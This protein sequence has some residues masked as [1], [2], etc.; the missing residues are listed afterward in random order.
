MSNQYFTDLDFTNT[1][2]GDLIQFNGTTTKWNNVTSASASTNIY[3][4]DGTLT[5]NRVLTQGAN[6]IDFV[7]T[8]NFTVDNTLPSGRTAK[9]EYGSGIFGTPSFEGAGTC[10]MNVG[11][12]VRSCIFNGIDTSGANL[13]QASLILQ[14]LPLTGSSKQGALNLA[15][16][17]SNNYSAQMAVVNGSG[18]VAQVLCQDSGAIQFVVT[19]VTPLVQVTLGTFRI[20]PLAGSG[21][22]NLGINAS[23]DVVVNETL[24][25]GSFG[26]IGLSNI[27]NCAV[28]QVNAPYYQQVG[29][30][31]NVHFHIHLSTLTVPSTFSFDMNLPVSRSTSGNFANTNEAQG[32][33]NVCAINS[34]AGNVHQGAGD[35]FMDGFVSSVTGAQT[36]R[37]QCGVA[38]I[39]NT[40][41]VV[42]GSFSYLI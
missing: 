26:G 11:G 13:N 19:G 39:V 14:E 21:T 23:G 29:N 1:Q 28:T 18:G 40:D 16:D 5:G 41:F 2:N 42:H 3:N 7:G 30:T 32:P 6:T 20:L 33:A 9:V 17:G 37:V 25:S 34:A 22:R 4:S 24:S 36:V 27:T 35:T 31:V 38:A 12:T 10:S 8:A 15:E